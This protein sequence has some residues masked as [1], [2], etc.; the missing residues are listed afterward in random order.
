MK[1]FSP[2][3][4]ASYTVSG[5]V[6]ITVTTATLSNVF[7]DVDGSKKRVLVIIDDNG[8]RKIYRAV[9]R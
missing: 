5:D 1:A 9:F 7:V 8:E 2:E 6:T 3:T 4:A